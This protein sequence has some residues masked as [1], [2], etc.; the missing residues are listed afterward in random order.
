MMKETKYPDLPI[1]K[2]DELRSQGKSIE[3]ISRELKIGRF[4][5]EKYL[6]K[7]KEANK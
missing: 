6:K 4:L 7:R 5:V 1:E 2:I 3:T